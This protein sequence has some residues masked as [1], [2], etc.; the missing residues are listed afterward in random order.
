MRGSFQKPYP[1]WGNRKAAVGN[2]FN[3]Q[4]YYRIP[5]RNFSTEKENPSDRRGKK[6][7]ID[8]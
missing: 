8:R 6:F 2:L 4:E 5:E 3:L 7:G 1:A